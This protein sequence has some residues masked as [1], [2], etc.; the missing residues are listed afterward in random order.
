MSHDGGAILGATVIAYAATV[1]AAPQ[2]PLSDIQMVAISISAGLFGG[3]LMT[4]IEDADISKRGLIKRMLA[5]AMAAPALLLA[6][7]EW[8]HREP[9]LLAV[10][11]ISGVAG[12]V[13]WPIATMLPKLAPKALK[14][15]LKNWI[16]DE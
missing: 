4:V 3:V 13:A 11:A 16:G 7:L 1:A 12:L 10:V 6:A 14:R 15:V 9:Y 5:S 2:V 8:S